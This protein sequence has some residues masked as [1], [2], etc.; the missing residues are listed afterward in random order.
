MMFLSVSDRRVISIT[1]THVMFPSQEI[2]EL[3][4]IQSHVLLHVRNPYGTQRDLDNAED[5]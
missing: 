2:E 5:K 1:F 3:E 4:N